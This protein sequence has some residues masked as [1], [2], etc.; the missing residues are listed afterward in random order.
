MKLVVKALAGGVLIPLLLGGGAILLIEGLSLVHSDL[1]MVLLLPVIWPVII[2][3]KIFPRPHDALLFDVRDTA[4]Q[5]SLAFDVLFY[6][7]LT[8]CVLRWRARRARLP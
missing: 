7:L 1:A 4:L 6:S 8:Y 2:F 3:G 5:A